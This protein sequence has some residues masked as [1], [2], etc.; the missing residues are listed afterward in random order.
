[1]NKGALLAA[2]LL[3]SLLL[4]CSLNA[5]VSPYARTP[6]LFVHGYGMGS[7][8]FADL[9]AHL[10]QQGYPPQLLRAVDLV[11][12]TGANVEAA[13]NQLEPAVE[14]FLGELNAYLAANQPGLPAKTRVD[15]VSHSMGSLSSR[16]YA[17][18]LRPDRVRR[19]L[20]LAGA[21]HGSSLAAFAGEV[22]GG[23]Q[24]MYPAFAAN[25]LESFIQF[26][27]NGSSAPDVD[28]TPYGLGTDSAGVTVVPPDAAR[29]I[30]YATI[31]ADGDDIWIDPDSSVQLDGAGGLP[32]TLPGDLPAAVLSPGNFRM[33]NGIGHDP[34]V[35]DP[36]TMRLV[37][38]L[39]GL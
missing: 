32:F 8:F 27:L 24:D 10:Q 37:G 6:V 23:E 22:D 34:M 2:A 28:E 31:A 25:E 33:T 9:R 15:L 4:G 21:N 30:F 11:P 26:Q 35:A 39:L 1:M 3:S 18:R 19:W 14:Q 13:V 7:S 17:A 38:L 20:S 29:S 16:W 12:N 5:R 36:Q